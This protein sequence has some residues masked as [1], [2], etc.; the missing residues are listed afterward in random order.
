MRDSN[1]IISFAV[2]FQV[3]VQG[4]KNVLVQG[5]P[6]F[7]DINELLNIITIGI[8]LIMYLY[9]FFVAR[10][11]RTPSSTI[12]ILFFVALTYLMTY[13]FFP[14]NITYVQAT[15]LRTLVCCLLTFWLVSKL[16]SF[17][18][19]YKYFTYGSF[20]I[21][22][23]GVLY[24]VIIGVIG[25]STTSEW[26]SYSM[27]M[28]NVLLL[29]VIWQFNNYFES[30]NKIMFVA[31][32]VGTIIIFLYGSRNPLLAIVF[33]VTVKILFSRGKNRQG[34]ITFI[35]FLFIVVAIF[36]VSNFKEILSFLASFLESLGLGSRTLYIFMNT[37]TEDITSGR[38]EIHEKLWEVILNDPFTCHGV[39]GDEVAIKELAHSLY[40][41]VFV[42]YGL[43]FGIIIV[44]W[45]ILH[46][47]KGLRYTTGQNYNIIL[48]YFCI[49]FPRSF[50]GGD[51]WANDYLWFFMALIISAFTQNRL[52]KINYNV[53]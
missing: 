45:L 18:Y 16:T 25:H 10:K 8:S 26:S 3:V 17:K 24:A 51:I 46:F 38:A 35:K 39:A 34:G 15:I 36:I 28:S 44:I 52:N 5:V 29:S 21:T 27:T 1:K 7:Y 48:M 33:F 30:R 47:I 13:M 50:S 37:D 20:L 32:V 43:V 53:L 23:S 14:E 4:C 19:L 2:A 42:T 49:V 12:G 9:A 40:L 31:A 22:L 6:F 41:S 11:R